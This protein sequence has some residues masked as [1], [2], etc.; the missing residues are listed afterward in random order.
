DLVGLETDGGEQGRI[1]SGERYASS[2]RRG[3]RCNR[4]HRGDSSFS[5]TL[6]DA[7]Q[8][9]VELFV[10]QVGMGVDKLRQHVQCT[11]EATWGWDAASAFSVVKWRRLMSMIFWICSRAWGSVTW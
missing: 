7:R 2:A 3:R 1:P 8:V 10:V 11:V 5:R 9:C 4:D 6:H